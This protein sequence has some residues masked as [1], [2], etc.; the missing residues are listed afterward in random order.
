MIFRSSL[1]VGTG[2]V[3]SP[4]TP[5]Y[6]SAGASIEVASRELELLNETLTEQGVPHVADISVAL[7]NIANDF[8]FSEHTPQQKLDT[9]TKFLIQ[10]HDI[11]ENTCFPKGQMNL[12]AFPQAFSEIFS[13]PQ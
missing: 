12:S 5:S 2:A 13:L 9:D 7:A 1:Q 10:T 8:I 6:H 11:I 3:E 4:P